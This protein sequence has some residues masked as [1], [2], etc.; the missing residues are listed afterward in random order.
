[1]E[2][3]NLYPQNNNQGFYNSPAPEQKPNKKIWKLIL[4]PFLF[5]IL[6]G[7]VIFLF[8]SSSSKTIS[9]NE[10]IQGTN[11][12][13]KQNNVAK[14]I[15]DNEEHTIKL[16]SVSG[17]SV[18]LIIQS[19]PVQLDIKIGEI[20]KIDLNDDGFYDLQIK[21]NGIENN[22]PE[23]HIKNIH[24]GIST[25]KDL[26]ELDISET[27]DNVIDYNSINHDDITLDIILPKLSY[28]VDEE[29]EGD[30]YLKYNGEPFKGAIISCD[31]SGCFKITGMI[32]DI[33]FN[34][35]E[36][37]NA[38]KTALTDTFY[39]EG[40]YNYSIYIYD[41]KDIDSEFNTDD[42][43]D[44]V[45]PSNIDIKDI[46]SDVTP[47]KFKSKS[48]IVTGENKEYTSKCTNNDDC[49]QTCTNCDKGT[50]VCVYSD[51]P[52][53]NQKCVECVNVFSCVD[54]YGCV[55][56]VCVIEECDSN[57]LNLCSDET[58]CTNT[59]GYW[60]NRECNEGEQA[61]YS[62]TNPDTIL[63]C[64][65]DDLS[66][67]LCSPEDAYGFTTQF[68]N[69]LESCELSQG[70]FALG[71]EPFM[72]IFRGYEIQSEQDS[73]CNIRFWFLENSVIDSS[74]LHKEMIC[75][76]DSSKRTAQSISDCFEECCS[77][78]LVD[79]ISEIQ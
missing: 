14:F 67:I 72:G 76:Y 78:G 55:D 50:Y 49:T 46:I 43:G 57:H 56:N 52:L 59:G 17:D 28:A 6:V 75:T 22:V 9:E 79:A 20:K 64:Y 3:Y 8:M 44:G 26:E 36:K 73:N 32:D 29:V 61:T 19:N 47:L 25:E 13:L 37:T 2:D 53:I 7:L 77:G 41:C 42:C 38:L 71:F 62:V 60:Y 15:I 30:F 5:V 70:T 27:N 12:K 23:L 51:N 65:N 66:E 18:N 11:L 35:P 45:W 63:D 39:Y 74:L 48:I 54:G 34:N 1:M 10:F 21:L 68:V 40:T 69:R 24:E 4:I 58:T 31:S 16:N 33:D